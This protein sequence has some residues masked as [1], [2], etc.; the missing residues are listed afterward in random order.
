VEAVV[1]I[2]TATAGPPASSV[3]A[4]A[5]VEPRVEAI[6]RAIAEELEPGMIVEETLIA[7]A[8][9]PAGAVEAAPAAPVVEL[10]AEPAPVDEPAPVVEVVVEAPA[11]APAP[12]V[13]AV[14]AAAPPPAATSAPAAPEIA[15]ETGM[16]LYSYLM[17]R[18][19]VDVSSSSA[20]AA[21]S[22]SSGVFAGDVHVTPAPRT[23]PRPQQRRGSVPQRP[24]ARAGI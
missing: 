2:A 11:A 12:V 8:E 5:A 13:I 10:I 1:V 20:P 3:D 17:P 15:P 21:P 16:G 18:G 6:A 19:D 14:V 9:P 24:G 7:V 22:A 23:A 4:D